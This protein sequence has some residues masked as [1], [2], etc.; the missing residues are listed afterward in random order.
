LA[1]HSAK[2]KAIR[3]SIAVIVNTTRSVRSAAIQRPDS[4][5]E[6][7]VATVGS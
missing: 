2:G 6:I 5:S 3:N 1:S 7:Q 4:I